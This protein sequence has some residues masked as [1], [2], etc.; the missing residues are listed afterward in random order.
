MIKFKPLL[1]PTLFTVPALIVLI[2]LGTWQVQRMMW[3]NGIIEA[4]NTRIAMPAIDMPVAVDNIDNMQYRKVKVKGEFMHN[5]EVH[6]FVGPRERGGDAGYN[7]VTPVKLT[8]G[9]YVLVDRGWVPAEKKEAAKRPETLVKG[10]VEFDGMVHKGE[11]KKSLVPDN[12]ITKNLWFW[13]DVPSIET[14]AGIKLQN[15]YVRALHKAGDKSLPI[16]GQDK[17]RYANDHLKYAITW[18]G[19]A[20]A[21]VVI[22][23]VYHIKRQKEEEI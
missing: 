20:I 10:V 4:V 12:D 19:L 18:Y 9:A 6:L 2:A 3:K 15:L 5:K 7:I 13:I 17:I 21:L 8:N 23:V 14:Y 1:Y 16:A 11:V 22:Y